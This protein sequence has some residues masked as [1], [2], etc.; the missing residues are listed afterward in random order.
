MVGDG[1]DE[2]PEDGVAVGDEVGG[3]DGAVGE[4]DEVGLVLDVGAG[5]VTT[6]GATLGGTLV[7]AVRSCCHDQPTEPPAGT[8]RAPTPYDEYVHDAFEP[9]A[10]QR[11]Q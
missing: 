9:S 4:G 1:V 2:P 3:L 7:P 5:A 6:G 11:P 10:H 8:V